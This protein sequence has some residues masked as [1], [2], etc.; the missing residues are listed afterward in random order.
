MNLQNR[1]RTLSSGLVGLRNCIHDQ[2][3]QNNVVS[4]MDVAVTNADN[5]LNRIP[6][7]GSPLSPL[8][9]DSIAFAN[10]DNNEGGVMLNGNGKIVPSSTL[11]SIPGGFVENG[12]TNTEIQQQ[13]QFIHG[14]F[15][16]LF[17]VL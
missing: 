16:R 6:D 17:I 15:R 3:Q 9:P 13:S 14:K 8:S 12:S 10:T 1:L 4:A 11:P 2:Q 5:G 7:S